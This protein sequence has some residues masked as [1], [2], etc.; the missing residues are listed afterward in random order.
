MYLNCMKTHT[1]M[2]SSQVTIRG[3]CTTVFSAFPT[4]AAGHNPHGVFAY[5]APLAEVVALLPVLCGRIAGGYGASR[6]VATITGFMRYVEVYGVLGA[7]ATPMFRPPM[8]YG[9]GCASLFC[10]LR[11][12]CCCPL[13]ISRFKAACVSMIS[14]CSFA[15]ALPRLMCNIYY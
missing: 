10:W 14:A 11:D 6:G 2:L 8:R 3:A 7:E 5:S 1:F 15:A 4:Y 13:V 9:C 12:I